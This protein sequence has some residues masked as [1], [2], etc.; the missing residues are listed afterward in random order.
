[1]G[2]L[3]RCH[4]IFGRKIMSEMGAPLGER[5]RG[6]EKGK[7]NW[8]SRKRGNSKYTE[9]AQERLPCNVIFEFAKGLLEFLFK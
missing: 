4:L 2:G 8:R 1:M 7:R 3:E 5:K 9:R 6:K